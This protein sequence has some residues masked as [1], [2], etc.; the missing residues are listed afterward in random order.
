MIY[1]K[2]EL[3]TYKSLLRSIFTY[4]S[5]VW[6]I[7]CQH[8]HYYYYYFNGKCW[9]FINLVIYLLFFFV[10]VS[11]AGRKSATKCTL[12]RSLSPYQCIH[13]SRP[14]PPP[15]KNIKITKVLF[16]GNQNYESFSDRPVLRRPQRPLLPTMDNMAERRR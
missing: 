1:I 3:A 11:A 5:P 12:N 13:H 2:L 4:V 10:A 8:L 9:C 16:A 6:G 7:C 15:R 14:P